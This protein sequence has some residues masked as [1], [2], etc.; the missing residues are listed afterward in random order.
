MTVIEESHN[1]SGV[2][3]ATL[4]MH[5]DDRGHF[6]ETFRK[7]WFPERSWDIIQ[8]NRSF[9]KAGVLRGLHYHHHQVDYWYPI[10]GRLRVGLCDLRRGSPT[11]GVHEAFVIDDEKPV[12]VLVP[13]GVAH[14]FLALTETCLTYLVDRYYDA[15]DEHGVAWDDPDIAMPWE[16]EA[17]LLSER[18]RQNPRLRDIPPAQLRTPEPC[19]PQLP[20]R[21]MSRQM[22]R[23]IRSPWYDVPSVQPSRIMVRRRAT[24]RASLRIS[25][26]F[27]PQRAEA[28]SGA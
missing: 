16:V 8:A 5:P 11:E 10:T 24:L 25:S 20:V 27:T 4:N 12:G 7:S 26:A 9:S 19:V 18:D 3:I 6:M 21:A 17:P 22:A 23:S 2:K 15:S 13:P 1:I 28:S 14:G